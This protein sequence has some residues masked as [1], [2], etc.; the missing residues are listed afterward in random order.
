MKS[1]Q[2]RDHS[3]LSRATEEIGHQ[4]QKPKN[5]IRVSSRNGFQASCLGSE[6]PQGPFNISENINIEVSG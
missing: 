5:A 2:G 4:A 6:R 1:Q 3:Y